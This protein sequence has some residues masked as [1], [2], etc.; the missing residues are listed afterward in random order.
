MAE[1]DF[2][3][4]IAKTKHPIDSTDTEITPRKVSNHQLN[5]AENS[6]L[7]PMETVDYEEQKKQFEKDLEALRKQYRPFMAD[8]FKGPKEHTERFC[9]KEFLFRYVD[10]DECFTDRNI[11]DK[12]W[13]TVTIPDY[14]GPVGKWNAYYKKNFSCPTGWKDKLSKGRRVV[15]AFQCVDYMA[16]VYVNGNFAGSHEGLFAPFSFDI[17]KFIREENELMIIVRNDVPILGE[18]EFLD[19][20]KIYAATGPGWDDPAVGW[21]HCPA[22]AG[23]FGKVS[24]ELRP[25]LYLDDIFVRPDLEN[26][27]AEVRIGAVNYTDEVKLDLTLSL[28]LAPK[29]YEGAPIGGGDFPVKAMGPGKNEYR[30]FLSLK[31]YRLWEMETPWLYGAGAVLKK[32]EKEISGKVQTFGLKSFVSD[33]NSDPK[34]RFNFNGRPIMLRGAN[35]M[36]HLQQCVMEGDFDQLV[37]DILIAKLCHMNYY[38]ITQRPVQEEI[39][40]YFDMLGM[41]HQCDFPLFGFLRRPQFAEAVRQ[42]GEMEHLVR[43]HVS[44]VMITFIN[45]PMCIRKT[46]DSNDKFSRRYDA[47][48]HRHLLRDELEAFFSAAR[49]AVYVENPDRVIKNVEGDYDGPTAEGMP[50]F[51]TYTMWYTNHGQPIG[52]LMRGYLPPVKSGWMMGCGEYGAEGL[53]PVDLMQRR[54]P[55]EW[56]DTDEQGHWYPDKIIRSQTHSVQGDWFK[57]Q[58]NLADWVRESQN[59]QARATK[60]MTDAFRRRADVINHTAVHLFIDAWPSGWMKALLDCERTPKRAFFAYQEALVPLKVNLYT[61]RSQVYED[62]TVPVEVWVLN[63]TGKDEELTVR[64]EIF[65]EGSDRAAAAYSETVRISAADAKC[66]GM[67]PVTFAKTGKDRNVK[68]QAAILNREGAVLHREEISLRVY[69]RRTLKTNV[70][71]IGAG[72]G[73]MVRTYGKPGGEESSVWILS[74]LKEEDI[75]RVKEH[76]EKGGKA[77]FLLPDKRAELSFGEYVIRTKPCGDLFFAAADKEWESYPVSFVYN[78]QKGYVDGTADHAIDTEMPGEALL[79]TYAKQGFLGSKGQKAHL[80]FVKQC[81]VGK[82]TLTLCTLKQEGRI[83]FNGGLDRLFLKLLEE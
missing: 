45:E 22:G 61:G 7:T 1:R 42:V 73:E 65:E 69:E 38:R 32:E 67:V 23:V 46:G 54:Y 29:N 48:G 43:R 53:D 50:D 51:H 72:A 25:E 10:K 59:H 74:S 8:Y 52:K 62:E 56:L 4:E 83:G 33:E 79:Y 64:A 39:Y 24:I 12:P 78:N 31:G 40:D 37:D 71:A 47:K 19:G 68:V 82:G 58:D 55:K 66:A 17:T 20:D 30:F 41:M 18:G 81:S 60:L 9:L 28:N 57:E 15:I 63:D 21:H 16:E 11:S 34:G 27:M 77:L 44:T 76:V 35:E 6:I 13:E 2:F 80:P 49:K 26:K 36:G 5:A 14:R 3:H 75:L 70:Y